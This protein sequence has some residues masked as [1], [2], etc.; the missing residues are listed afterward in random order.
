MISD[1][2]PDLGMEDVENK[3]SDRDIFYEKIERLKS[4]KSNPH[5]IKALEH[6]GEMG[7]HD[8]D[9]IFKL[10]MKHNC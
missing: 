5:V 10:C 2:Q 7:F 3:A 1:Q 9:R 4:L 8:Y 6:F